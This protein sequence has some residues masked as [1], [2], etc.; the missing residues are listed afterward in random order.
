MIKLIK[1]LWKQLNCEHRWHDIFK[2]DRVTEVYC[3]KCWK[4]IKL[5]IKG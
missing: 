4:E 5:P 2:K 1:K 3:N